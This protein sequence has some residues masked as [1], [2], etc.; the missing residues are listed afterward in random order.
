MAILRKI[1]K[2][3]QISTRQQ[4]VETI[5]S[6]TS[7]VT[8]S[9]LTNSMKSLFASNESFSES[10]ISAL[11]VSLEKF[12]QGL[13]SFVSQVV[14]NSKIKPEDTQREMDSYAASIKAGAYA[15]MGCASV[16]SYKAWGTQKWN[17]LEAPEGSFAQYVGETDLPARAI[18]FSPG[19]EGYRDDADYRNMMNVTVGYN[20][21]AARQDPFAEAFFGTTV[22]GP[23]DPGVVVTIE[24]PIIHNDVKYDTTGDVG[25]LQQHSLV[26]AYRDSSILRADELVVIPIVTGDAANA[27]HF[28]KSTALPVYNTIVNGTSEVVSTRPLAFDVNTNLISI[29]QSESLLATGKAE[30]SDILDRNFRL[31][32]VYMVLTDPTDPTKKEAFKYYVKEMYQATFWPHPQEMNQTLAVDFDNKEFILSWKNATTYVANAAGATSTILSALITNK[33]T[34]QLTCVVTGKVNLQTQTVNL[35]TGKPTINKLFDEQMEEI[36]MSGPIFDQIKAIVDLAVW[37]SYDVDA[38]RANL[39]KRQRGRLCDSRSFTEIRTVK[40]GT[41]LSVVRPPV[42]NDAREVPDLT[43]LVA[44]SRVTTTN[45]AIDALFSFRDTM[46]QRVDTPTADGLTLSNNIPGIARYLIKP[47]FK[48]IT[49]DLAEHLN[50]LESKDAFDNISSVLMN[51]IRNEVY[52]AYQQSEYKVAYDTLTGTDT[53]PP[54][55]TCGTDQVLSQFLMTTGDLRSLGN[56]FNMQTVST[57]NE[58]VE[59]LIIC[60]FKPSLESNGVVDPMS[61]GSHIW[62]PEIVFNQQVTRNGQISRE[63]TVTP[64]FEHFVNCPVMI[65]FTVKNLPKAFTT[66]TFLN[67]NTVDITP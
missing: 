36:P 23:E 43:K 64:S 33:L 10:D 31:K 40:L 44:L 42:S 3:S 16:E 7:Q 46:R 20:F 62:R 26:R 53:K 66:K 22:I 41:P 48:E 28:T 52:I 56:D 57:V 5:S 63:T 60:T 50:N 67:V 15:A 54:I 51:N 24:I 38:R 1:S 12:E 58:A 18:D 65:I 14:S 19:L 37:D 4:L 59:N 30:I 55:V 49:I 11:S 47:Y 35:R 45:S 39:N 25:Q 2:N 17:S 32:N 9:E 34:V 27:N 21:N 29:S 8:D 61:F 6:M 13:T